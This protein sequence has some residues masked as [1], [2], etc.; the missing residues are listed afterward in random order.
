MV[1]NELLMQFQSDILDVPVIRPKVSETTALG[2]AY[3]AGLAVGF[4]S[5]RKE[6]K[7]NW[8]K[9]KTWRPAMDPTLRKTYVQQWKK[10]VER[11]FNWV[12]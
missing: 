5:G 11:T 7:Q 4:W 1:G 6:L 2:A 8:S 10:S 12:D 3:A 9:D